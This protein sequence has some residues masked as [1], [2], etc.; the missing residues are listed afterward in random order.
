MQKKIQHWQSDKE[1]YKQK[2]NTLK[3]EVVNQEAEKNRMY[4][5]IASQDES[6][7]TPA[8]SAR[9]FTDFS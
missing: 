1:K 6:P 4:K 8:D 7:R 5:K 2:Y 3:K 9:T